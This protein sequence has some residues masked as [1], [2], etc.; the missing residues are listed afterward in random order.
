MNRD[1]DALVAI[2]KVPKFNRCC[3]SITGCARA[4]VAVA[5]QSRTHE[6]RNLLVRVLLFDFAFFQ[7]TSGSDNKRTAANILLIELVRR[8]I[9]VGESRA[10]REAWAASSETCVLRLA[11]RRRCIDSTRRELPESLMAQDL[12][13]KMSSRPVVP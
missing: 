10:N 9:I 11:H 2:A 6:L 12:G 13:E 1:A 7:E 4:L 8:G 5:M 3:S